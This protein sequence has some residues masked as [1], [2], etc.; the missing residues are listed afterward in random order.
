MGA[1]A[2]D[3][4][5]VYPPTQALVLDPQALV[6]EPDA[7]QGQERQK[8]KVL[9]GGTERASLTFGVLSVGTPIP[10]AACAALDGVLFL[11]PLLRP[12][13][14]PPMV[15]CSLQGTCTREAKRTSRALGGQ[16]NAHEHLKTVGAETTR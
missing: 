3:C 5:S 4:A 7:L 12:E 16:H 9:E 13:P 11:E 14:G 1:H 6:F 15:W 2:N 8:R 10:A